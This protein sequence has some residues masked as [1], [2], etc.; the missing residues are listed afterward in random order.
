MIWFQFFLCDVAV[1]AVEGES[2]NGEPVGDKSVALLQLHQS[3]SVDSQH[4]VTD[5]DE[6]GWCIAWHYWCWCDPVKRG[7]LDRHDPIK[8]HH[9]SHHNE[10]KGGNW[11]WTH[12]MQFGRCGCGDCNKR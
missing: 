9:C 2:C 4:N 3:Q 11:C 7:R 5:L 1:H 8:V 6:N 10:S 12:R